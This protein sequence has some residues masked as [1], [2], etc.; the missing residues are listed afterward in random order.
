MDLQGMLRLVRLIIHRHARHM[1][2][3]VLLGF[4]VDGDV[5]QWRAESGSVAAC[6]PAYCNGVSRTHDDDAVDLAAPVLQQGVRQRRCAAGKRVTRVRRDERLGQVRFDASLLGQFD[7]RGLGISQFA[8]DAFA[9]DERV[10]GIERAG[11]GWCA[12]VGFTWFE[13]LVGSEY[14]H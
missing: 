10:G 6:H 8:V 7:H 12:H 4:A 3:Q 14:R 13:S 9:K 1:V 2:E 11:D 5:P